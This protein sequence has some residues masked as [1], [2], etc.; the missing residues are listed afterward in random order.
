MRELLS[1]PSSP[2]KAEPIKSIIDDAVILARVGRHTSRLAIQ[3][4]VETAESSA[5]V[6]EIHLRIVFASL[7]RNAFEACS[8]YEPHSG[9][10]AIA[11]RSLDEHMSEI[12]ITDD[13]P[14]Y[15]TTCSAIYLSRFIQPETAAKGASLYRPVAEL[16]KRM[17]GRSSHLIHTMAA[18][19]LLSQFHAQL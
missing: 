17:E 1:N 9:R 4:S 14:A 12:G 2:E 16:R 7:L 5:C 18:H 8:L 19:A 10:I 15:Q 6:N 13:V 3:I 11:V